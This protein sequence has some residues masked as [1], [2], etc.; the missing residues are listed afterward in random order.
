MAKILLGLTVLT[1]I[2]LGYFARTIASSWSPAPS[3]KLNSST[4]ILSSK[5]CEYGTVSMFLHNDKTQPLQANQLT[6]TWPHAHS[7]Q[8]LLTLR[9]IE[10]D[11]G[12][13][14][15]NL[16][17]VGHNQYVTDIILPVCTNS[18]MTWAADITDGTAIVSTFIRMTK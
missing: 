10:M 16:K 2:V 14:K 6:V 12:I 13:V 11:M 4:C 8:L 7:S 1:A 9:G 18:E 17:P 3:V 15:Y 5:L